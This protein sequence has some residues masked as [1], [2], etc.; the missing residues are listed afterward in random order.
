MRLSKFTPCTAPSTADVLPSQPGIY[1]ITQ[2]DN[3]AAVEAFIQERF[4]EQYQARVNSIANH[5]MALTDRQQQLVAAFGY[6]DAA[7]QALFLE[8][9]LPQAV[10]LVLADKG[11]GSVQREQI[12]EV[13]NLAAISS[14]STRRLILTLITHFYQQ[15]YRWLVMTATP[16]VLNSFQRL[17]IDLDLLPLTAADPQRLTQKNDDWGRY[18]D[19]KP[20]V[21]A[22]SFER[23]L[24]RM[25]QN[26]LFASMIDRAEVPATDQHLYLSVP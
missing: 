5:L 14:G 11:C 10:E 22:G 3:Q 8:Q 21:Y 23:A 24:T 20:Y 26:P 18:Y 15:G 6:Q 16:Q 4:Y 7:S 12:L 1:T 19:E 25:R 9:Y 2:S 17:G 13:G